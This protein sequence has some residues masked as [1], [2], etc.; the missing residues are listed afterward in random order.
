MKKLLVL[1]GCALVFTSCTQEDP[2]APL[3]E[4]PRETIVGEVLLFELSVATRATHRLERDEK[5]VALLASDIVELVEFEGQDVSVTGVRRR[6][7]MREIFIVDEL[8]LLSDELAKDEDSQLPERF[9]TKNFSFVFPHSWQYSTAPDGTMHFTEKTDEHGRVFLQFTVAQK[10]RRDKKMTATVSIGEFK[11]TKSVMGDQL[12]REHQKIVL[13]SNNSNK[14]YT[15]SFTANFE[16]FEKKKAFFQLLNSFLEGEDAVRDAQNEER[17]L[18]AERE[19]VKVRELTKVIEPEELVVS[20]IES[21]ENEIVEEKKE[22]IFSRLFG[23]SEEKIDTEEA[24]KKAAKSAADTPL[25]NDYTNL[26]DAKAF[27]YSSTSLKFSMK[28]PW[29]YWFK[30]VGPTDPLLLQFGFAK[31][32]ISG[33]V[34]SEFFLEI[35]PSEDPVVTARE[36]TVDETLF[37]EWARNDNSFF[38][39]HGPATA[40]DAMRSVQSTVTNL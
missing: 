9:S 1:F 25:K 7:K 28:A 21:V 17:R 3:S 8:R 38:R 12:G 10:E 35:V 24:L 14:K 26:I 29:G 34:D 2:F 19:A 30:N 5:L 4:E 33:I 18:Q 40:R 16:E 11:G 23:D 27:P 36:R 6:E 32:E 22:G 13:W 39:L 15:F 37:V 31:H 20:E